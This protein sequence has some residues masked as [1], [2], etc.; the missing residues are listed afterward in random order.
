M[1]VTIEQQQRIMNEWD[2]KFGP[3]P[4][5]IQPGDMTCAEIVE[6]YKIDKAEVYKKAKNGEILKVKVYDPDQQST[7]IVYRLP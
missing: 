2:K 1:N 7:I 3:P 5:E 6:R 4:E